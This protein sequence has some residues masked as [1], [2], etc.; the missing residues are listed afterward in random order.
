MTADNFATLL[1]I[2]V[3]AAVA[4][5]IVVVVV[6]VVVVVG[7]VLKKKDTHL[8]AV[9]QSLSLPIFQNSLTV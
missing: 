8:M 7:I 5:A 9:I 3:V 2:V 6:V 4:V 1:S